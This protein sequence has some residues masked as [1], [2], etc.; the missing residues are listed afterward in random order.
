ME[1]NHILYTLVDFAL[2]KEVKN[3]GDHTTYLKSGFTFV[4][5]VKLPPICPKTA[6]RGVRWYKLDKTEMD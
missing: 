3:A 2:R 4:F 1:S 6:V 5:C